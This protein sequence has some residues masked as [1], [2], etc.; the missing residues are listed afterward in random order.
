M[1]ILRKKKIS[2]PLLFLFVLL[3]ASVV[4]ASSA[5]DFV[6][7]DG[8]LLADAPMTADTRSPDVLIYTTSPEAEKKNL[9][10][11]HAGLM[12]F[13][14]KETGKK[15][16]YLETESA[17]EEIEKMRDGQLH[18]AGFSTGNVGFAVNIAGFIPFCV[19]AKSEQIM[20]Y[21]LQI[22]VSSKGTYRSL[23]DLKG[24]V[25]AHTSATS[26]SGNIAPRALL[27]K[28]GL[29]P[30]DTYQVIYSG[31][32]KKSIMGVVDGI[33]PAAAVASSTLQRMIQVGTIT[34]SDIR[35]LYT[36]PQF[37]TLAMG[38]VYDLAP[39]LI[40]QIC[41]AFL[42]Y[43]FSPETVKAFKGATHYLP[44]SYKDD[45]E[46]IRHIAEYNGYSYTTDG[47]QK[48]LQKKQK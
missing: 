45:W 14:A 24:K 20:G 39:G 23:Q 38:Y 29:L 28:F 11:R 47:L 33:Y 5:F 44:I 46:I 40:E 19:K 26:N 32:H 30:D 43:S 7:K 12:A 18:I 16:V 21:H 6:D 2:S 27:P 8:D 22:I 34:E 42:E 4:S 3:F 35:I 10:V 15:V 13:I 9:S 41:Y 1:D 37:P 31:S 36:S 17:L 25:L 48:M